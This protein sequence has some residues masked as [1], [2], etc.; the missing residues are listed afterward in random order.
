MTRSWHGRTFW[1]PA[2]REYIECTFLMAWGII[3]HEKTL[4]KVVHLAL[5]DVDH[6]L[7]LPQEIIGTKPAITLLARFEDDTG[8]TRKGK[9]EKLNEEEKGYTPIIISKR[10]PFGGEEVRNHDQV[11]LTFWLWHP[12]LAC[13]LPERLVVVILKVNSSWVMRMRRK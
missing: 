2:G 4:G 7:N 5:E 12:L 11:T 8:T 13:V 6:P 9:S 1:Y 10:A 3:K